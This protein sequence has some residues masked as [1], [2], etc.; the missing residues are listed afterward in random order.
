MRVQHSYRARVDIDSGKAAVVV[1]AVPGFVQV[2]NDGVVWPI[3]VE[4]GSGREGESTETE[5]TADQARLLAQV[6]YRFADTVEG[7]AA[8]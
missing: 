8:L 6:L 1:F 7:R 3:V 5:M 2:R 4:V